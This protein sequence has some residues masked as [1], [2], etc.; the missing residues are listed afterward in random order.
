MTSEIQKP[1][2]RKHQHVA[3]RLRELAT[4][5]QPGERLPS[6]ADLER[7]LGVSNGTVKVALGMLRS[8]GLVMSRP[9]SGNYV[10]ERPAAQR[11]DVPAARLARANTQTLA[12]LALY[13][14]PFFKHLAD[15][16]TARAME[17]GLGVVCRYDDHKMS[18]DDALA[19]ERLD[20][21]GFFILG[22]ELEWVGRQITR[23]GRRVVLFGEPPVDT[24]ASVPNVYGGSEQGGYLATRRLLELGH[25]RLLYAHCFASGEELSMRRRWRGHLRALREAGV[26]PTHPVIGQT[27]P[28]QWPMDA[29]DALFQGPNAPTGIVAWNDVYGSSMLAALGRMGLRVPADISLIGYDNLPVSLQTDPPLDTVDQHLD[30]QIE[31]AFSLLSMPPETGMV[32][33]MTVAPTLVPR[34]SCARPAR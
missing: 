9:R 6:V 13:S 26:D 20:P 8:E 34:A 14:N 31:Q 19:L 24:V 27:I 18:L 30:I 17:R 29:V 28:G 10:A 23:R 3:Q 7:Q 12:V 33:A 32:P 21:A 22:W 16:V 25:R 5:M 11:P 4:S 1:E 15:H 2:P